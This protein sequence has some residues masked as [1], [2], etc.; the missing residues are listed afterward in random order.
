MRFTGP[1]EVLAKTGWLS[2]EPKWLRDALLECSTLRSFEA[3]DFTHMTGDE[4]GG[5]FGIV[6]GSF[7]VLIPTMK[8]ELTVCHVLGVGNWFG[9]GPIL[10]DGPRSM[11]YRALE[12]SQVLHASY[13]DVKRIGRRQPQL[14]HRIGILSERSYYAVGIQILGDLLIPS[15]ERRVAAVL[16]RLG[17]MAIGNGQVEPWAIHL[18]QSEIGEMCNC[19]RDRVNRALQKF[20]KAGWIGVDIKKVIV[21]NRAALERFAQGDG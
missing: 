3:G 10:T 13:G 19:S 2:T 9:I 18:S 14:Y 1:K 6:S 21:R 7:G 15:S 5:I 8:S 11:S 16:R 20:A 4:P 12:K 17:G